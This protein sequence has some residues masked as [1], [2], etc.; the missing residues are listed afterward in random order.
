[1]AMV[2]IDVK[3]MLI[4][5]SGVDIATDNRSNSTDLHDNSRVASVLRCFYQT[6]PLI[7]D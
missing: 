1:M 3:S 2:Y 6:I 4:V 5:I 7:Y